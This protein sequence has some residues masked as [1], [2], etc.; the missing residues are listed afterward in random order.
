MGPALRILHVTN[1][2]GSL[3]KVGRWL[4]ALADG[5]GYVMKCMKWELTSISLAVGASGVGGDNLGKERERD[6]GM[7]HYS[8]CPTHPSRHCHGFFENWNMVAAFQALAPE[9]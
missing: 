5:E 8:N 1:S 9:C 3:H 2:R 4:R 7:K 6:D